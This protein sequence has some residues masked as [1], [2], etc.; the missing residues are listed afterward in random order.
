MTTEEL[1]TLIE[2]DPQ[3]L[4][5]AEAGNDTGCA[6]RL[7][8][9]A[10]KVLSAEHR[11]SAL[12]ILS[13]FADPA[14]GA[15]AWAKLKAAGASNPVVALAVEFMGPGSVA[16]LNIA[17]DRSQAMCDAL[18]AAGVWTQAQCDTIKG[19]GLVAAVITAEQVSEVM[20]PDRVMFRDESDS[21]SPWFV[22]VEGGQ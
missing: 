4:E 21:N 19:L 7:S 20:A 10:P 14:V 8:E 13:A 18:R 16:G 15:D 3:A 6:A 5:L 1:R 22:P 17:D 2:S 9:I 11:I 12:T